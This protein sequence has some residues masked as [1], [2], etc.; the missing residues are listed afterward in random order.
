MNP[1]PPK[2]K[3]RLGLMG[4]AALLALSWPFLVGAPA[5]GAPAVQAQ[6]G[7]APAGEAPAASA[8]GTPATTTTTTRTFTRPG[9]SSF[10]VPASVSMVT[11]VAAGAPGGSCPQASTTGGLGAA[12]TAEVPVS[13][14]ESLAL[15]VGGPGDNCGSPGGGVG[16]G[17]GGGKGGSGA[18]GHLG[19]AGGGGATV[20]QVSTPSPTLLLWAG[21]GGG[22]AA[23]VPQA[24]TPANGGNAAGT[25]GE[26]LPDETGGND[27]GQPGTQTR[28]GSGS[29]GG[30][31]L[32]RGFQG[33]MGAGGTGAR[34]P[35]CEEG[36]L[37]AGGGGGGGY[38][39]G[40][41]G[42]CAERF[43]PAGGGGG[44]SFA[45][46]AV[47][48]L[49]AGASGRGTAGVSITYQTMPPSG[50]VQCLHQQT[51]PAPAPGAAVFAQPV[52][53]DGSA[54]NVVVIP[55]GATWTAGS[56]A[57]DAQAAVAQ[58]MTHPSS[59]EVGAGAAVLLEDR[60]VSPP[61]SGTSLPVLF[62]AWGAQDVSPGDPGPVLFPGRTDWAT[63]EAEVVDPTYLLDLFNSC[64]SCSLPKVNFTPVQAL[65]PQLIAYAGNVSDADLSGAQL[66]GGVF[67]G[68]NLSGTNLSGAQLAS[69][70]LAGATLDHTIVDGTGFASTD[71][72]G[73]QFTSLQFSTPPLFTGVSIGVFNGEC[74]T[75]KDTDL[76]NAS[77]APVKF[78]GNCAQAPLLPGS[79]APTDLLYD[80]TQIFHAQIDLTGTEFV[81][82]Y[83]DRALLAG[84]DLSGINLDDVRFVG[85]PVDLSRTDLDGAS[86][87]HA[88][89]ELADLSGATLH[90]VKAAGASFRGAELQGPAS[91]GGASFAGSN[92]DLQGADFVEADVSGASFSGA[93]LTG[94]VFSRAL[95]ADTDFNGVRAANADFDGAHIYGN[96]EA[97]SSATNLQGAD[98]AGA[99]LAGNVDQGGGFDL[100]KTNLTGAKF[101]GADCVG[102]N[103]SGSRLEQV[104]FSGAYL[105]G[106]VFSG[107]VTLN[108]ANFVNAWLYCGDLS[109]SSCS[110]VPGQTGRW[111]WPLELGAGEAFGPVPFADTNLKGVSLD[112]VAV[113][114]DGKAG[115]VAPAGCD[116]HLLPKTVHAPVLPPPCSSA[117]SDACPTATSTLFDASGVGSPLAVV[118]EIPP[119]WATTRS[120]DGYY[121]AFDDG[122]IRLLGAGA[123]RIVAG[124]AGQHCA[125]PTSPCG[126]GGAATTALL[127]TPMSLAVGLDGSIYVADPALHRVR[128]IDPSGQISTVAGDGNTC[129]TAATWIGPISRGC[130]DGGPATAAALAGPYGV[131]ASPTGQLY[132]ADGTRG[133]RDVSPAGGTITTINTGSYDVRSIVGDLSGNLYAATSNPDY[134]IKITPTGQVTTVVGTGTSGYNGNTNAFGSLSPGTAVQINDPQG[135]S[136]GL[137]GDVVFADTGNNLIRAYVPSSGHVIDE[138]AGLVSK[139]K[140][141]G[142]FNGDGHWPD[143]TE[144]DQP[145]A[146][147]ATGSSLYVIVDAGN[148]RLRQFGPSPLDEGP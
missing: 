63:T 148:R 98:F 121:A 66:D 14:G 62:S 102:C 25:T 43:G 30:N 65:L 143:Q 19:G 17:G 146:V 116:G 22:A 59:I 61:P 110:A 105:P 144:L 129:T 60:P 75:F 81:S 90:N 27:G 128:R 20:V 80:I 104:N 2:R 115:S 145:L 21:G 5:V 74:T 56:C 46:S 139:G 58:V 49:I 82:S 131:W 36:D 89:F 9:G 78:I 23:S 119:T 138:L 64:R 126:D 13:P 57:G 71:L 107:V 68:W 134:L 106:A 76:V 100:T 47:T 32:A 28:G 26:T 88:S 86:L 147:V 73:A 140:P 35:A 39:G 77:F 18:A 137:D 69:A 135:L 92:T 84:K 123:P 127:G 133:I 11:V 15:S 48:T 85:F 16:G 51:P 41:G 122:T 67:D 70:S 112:D 44:S 8:T 7:G 130:G 31:D 132:I 10:T 101:D 87:Q 97:F 108:G 42:G 93:D 12:V 79:S 114:P 83:E 109:D 52:G 118:P 6:A 3:H 33:T 1:H 120:G 96:G 29:H 99:V 142:G 45:S 125:T 103:F 95:A 113:C 24:L 91:V 37:D 94:A 124:Q 55:A 141:Q 136:L 53:A 34:G 38:Y 50:T 111:S 72:R 117:G 4:S 54:P 40:G